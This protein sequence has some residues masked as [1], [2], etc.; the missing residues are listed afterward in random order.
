MEYARNMMVITTRKPEISVQ[1]R[2]SVAVIICS[3]GFSLSRCHSLTVANST[4]KAIKYPSTA[5]ALAIPWKLADLETVHE[6]KEHC[7]SNPL[8]SKVWKDGGNHSVQSNHCYSLIWNVVQVPFPLYI[9]CWSVGHSLKGYKVCVW[10]WLASPFCWL[11]N[12][13]FNISIE[14]IIKQKA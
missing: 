4:K 7:F 9:R 12:G 5:S 1:A 10:C 8:K 14:I 3:F 2:C 13:N 11:E 6:R